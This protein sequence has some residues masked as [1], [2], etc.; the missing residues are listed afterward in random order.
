M[1]SSENTNITHDTTTAQTE[2]ATPLSPSSSLVISN[3]SSL[4]P[5]KLT[6]TNYLLWKSLFKPILRGHKLMHLI[7]GTTPTPIS[8]TSLWYEKDQMLLSWINATLSVNALPYIVGISSAKKAWDIL[9]QRYA[10]ATPAHIM[11]LERQ[12]SSI[13]KVVEFVL[14]LLATWLM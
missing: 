12:L 9:Q 4:I 10:S 5:I 14:S 3:I 6:S 11:S 2:L 8:P 13:K 1:A 7:D